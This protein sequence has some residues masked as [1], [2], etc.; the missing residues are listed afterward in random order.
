MRRRSEKCIAE[1]SKYVHW[2]GQYL[3]FHLNWVLGPF[4]HG[5]LQNLKTSEDT[6]AHVIT[7]LI[8]LQHTILF[9][10]LLASTRFLSTKPPVFDL[11]LH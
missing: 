11:T 2:I 1:G 3:S 8:M 4:V 7:P 10:V 9:M 5:R 6:L